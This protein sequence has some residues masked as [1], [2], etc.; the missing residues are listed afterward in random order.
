MEKEKVIQKIHKLLKLQFGAE[1]IGS[2]N[3]AFQAAKMVKKLLV[4]HNLSMSDIGQDSVQE[5]INISQSSEWSATDRY[6]NH[7]KY[8]L[9]IVIANNNFCHAYKRMNH[10]MFVVGTE[11]N[12]AVVKEFY[13]YLVKV[14]RR[15]SKERWEEEFSMIE[16]TFGPRRKTPKTEKVL[17][18]VETKFIR[19]YLEGV[20]FGLQAN[21]DSLK[22]TSEETALTVCHDEAINDYVHDNYKFNDTPSRNRTRHVYG[23]AYDFGVSDGV[24]V[25]LNRQIS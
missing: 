18:S 23:D 2:T 25:S 1:K 6:G 20:P 10:F 19:S 15:L 22:P 4:E 14:F 13:D 8:H 3:E 9:L 24:R 7:W 17:K 16:Q 12:V 11:D 21:Y 5:A